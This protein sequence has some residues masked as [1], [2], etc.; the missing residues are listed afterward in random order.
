LTVS[1]KINDNYA[2]RGVCV[3][4]GILRVGAAA[5]LALVLDGIRRR[6]RVLRTRNGFRPPDPSEN[7]TT[8]E[9]IKIRLLFNPVDYLRT[10]FHRAHACATGLNS[11]TYC[12]YLLLSFDYPLATAIPSKP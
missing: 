2:K 10:T 8:A 9:Q 7:R 1:T 12:Y 6:T 5:L 3:C 4:F 11:S